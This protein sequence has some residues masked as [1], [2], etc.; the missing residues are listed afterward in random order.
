MHYSI[1]R[2]FFAA[3][4][5][6]VSARGSSSGRNNIPTAVAAGNPQLVFQGYSTFSSGLSSV[7]I[8]AIKFGIDPWA[9]SMWGNRFEFGVD[10]FNA[11]YAPG[12]LISGGYFDNLSGQQAYKCFPCKIRKA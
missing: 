3:A 1:L 12:P 5:P 7:N 2:I 9:G 11:P 10:S 4:I 6:A 8:A